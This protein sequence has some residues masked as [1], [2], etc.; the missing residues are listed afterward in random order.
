M[1]HGVDVG[2]LPANQLRRLIDG[3]EVY[4]IRYPRD[5]GKPDPDWSPRQ[6]TWP[7]D[8]AQAKLVWPRP[9]WK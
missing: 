3:I 9:A 7:F 6:T 4:P 1:A 8:F 5:S 2:V